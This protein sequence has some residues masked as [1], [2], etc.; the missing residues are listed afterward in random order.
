MRVRRCAVLWLES[1]EVAH[2]DLE[3]LLAGGT[4]IHSR[5]QWFAHAPHLPAPVVVD[6]DALV[7]LGELSPLDWV[8]VS[9]LRE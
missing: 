8:A 2:F 9:P 7:L 1:R 4:G 3:N 5:L 6:A